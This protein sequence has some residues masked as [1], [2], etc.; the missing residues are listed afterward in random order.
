MIIVF[1]LF[2]VELFEYSDFC[3]YILAKVSSMLQPYAFST[4]PGMF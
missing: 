1:M 2:F 4:Y 3:E